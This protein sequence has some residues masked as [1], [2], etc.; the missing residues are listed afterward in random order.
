MSQVTARAQAGIQAIV[1]F[2]GGFLV[3]AGASIVDFFIASVMIFFFLREGHKIHDALVDFMPLSKADAEGLLGVVRDTIKANFYGV[4]GVAVVQGAL[5]LIGLLI[6][7]VPSA[8]T[9]AAFATAF[10]CIP[11]VGPP[12]VWVPATIWL[13]STGHPGAAVFLAAWGVIV[14]GLADNFLRPALVSGK[15]NQN[16]MLVF[17]S[18]IGGTAAFGILGLFV[19]PLLVSITIAVF[20]VLRREMGEEKSAILPPTSV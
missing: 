3:G 4:V 13:A 10:A 11:M 19:G 16:S 7:G 17:F 18:L 2:T 20:K 14:V 5:T 9:W 15:T 12:L 6:A 8:L 1:G